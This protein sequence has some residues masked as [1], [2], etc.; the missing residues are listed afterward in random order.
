[1]W[2]VF[3]VKA[4]GDTDVSVGTF[5]QDSFAKMERHRPLDAPIG[6]ASTSQLSW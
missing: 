6:N 5:M 1:M 4:Q 3:N 2:T